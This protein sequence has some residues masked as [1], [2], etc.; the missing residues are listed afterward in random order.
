MYSDSSQL[1]RQP[2]NKSF[3]IDFLQAWE[4]VKSALQKDKGNQDFLSDESFNLSVRDRTYLA[5]KQDLNKTK[6]IPS[7]AAKSTQTLPKLRLF[8]LRSFLILQRFKNAQN[9]ANFRSGDT[10]GVRSGLPVPFDRSDATPSNPVLGQTQ[11][12][13]LSI[14]ASFNLLQNKSP[15]AFKQARTSP[16]FQLQNFKI[17]DLLGKKA[18]LQKLFKDSTPPKPK[19]Y[20]KPYISRSKEIPITP[21][22]ASELYDLTEFAYENRSL[23]PVKRSEMKKRPFK[24]SDVSNLRS[25]I[26]LD[27]KT[28]EV[29]RRLLM[30]L[31]RILYKPRVPKRK[32]ELK[33]QPVLRVCYF[34]EHEEALD[35]AEPKPELLPL[36]KESKLMNVPTLPSQEEFETLKATLE[37]KDL[38]KQQQLSEIEQLQK[39]IGNL[40]SQLQSFL[41]TNASPQQAAAIIAE[42]ELQIKFNS[43]TERLKKLL[44]ENIRLK[45]EMMDNF[46]QEAGQASENPNREKPVLSLNSVTIIKADGSKNTIVPFVNLQK[47]KE[48]ASKP[49]PP[50][51]RRREDDQEELAYPP[52]QVSDR[53]PKAK[54]KLFF[55]NFTQLAR[56]KI[57]M[58]AEGTQINPP[59]PDDS[60]SPDELEKLEYFRIEEE[61]NSLA[62]QLKRLSDQLA[63]E[64]SAKA[65]IQSE[66][67]ALQ[68]LHQQSASSAQKRIEELERSQEFA[69]SRK[70]KIE[71]EIESTK[72][73][74]NYALNLLLEDKKM[75]MLEKIRTFNPTL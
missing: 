23:T 48:M 42:S 7:R 64:T 21:K 4:D 31:P 49:Q 22:I 75:D 53:I 43:Q 15:R 19:Y 38:E 30:N 28:P 5:P 45:K 34:T 37:K 17:F 33:V 68:N 62:K 65:K 54:I 32:R 67:T 25:A 47:N 69:E 70:T 10:Q 74:L 58:V 59:P 46:D 55:E 13:V 12:P 27:K 18:T 29:K 26:F 51:D 36:P 39:T 40:K 41:L 73:K 56:N 72:A 57:P 52:R 50:S 66:L 35:Q 14:S 9:S 61:R 63:S 20:S 3:E 71:K 8:H 44:N 1:L 11:R 60:P 24:E 2:G 6:T 16:Q